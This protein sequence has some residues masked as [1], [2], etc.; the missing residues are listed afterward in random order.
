MC[1]TEALDN[2]SQNIC[3]VL[4]ASVHLQYIFY[5]LA[6]QL[7]YAL[8]QGFQNKQIFMLL[9]PQGLVL[10]KSGRNS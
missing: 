4:R 10:G 6:L 5:F 2:T 7:G 3:I 8:L 9:T 1:A